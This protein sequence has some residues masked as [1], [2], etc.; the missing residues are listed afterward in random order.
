MLLLIFQLW[1]GHALADFALQNDY[2]AKAKNRNEPL[3]KGIWGWPLYA[4][5]LIHGGIVTYMTGFLWL[6]VAEV[7]AHMAIDFAKTEGHLGKHPTGYHIDQSLHY[8]CKIVW[9]YIAVTYGASLS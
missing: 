6:G 2:V 7:I 1:F 5:G 3:G 8:L 9:A 4:H